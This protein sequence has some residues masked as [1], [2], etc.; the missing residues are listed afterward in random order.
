MPNET[1][2]SGG[3]NP[4]IE[5]TCGHPLCRWLLDGGW[6]EHPENR[7]DPSELW[8]NG[9]TPSVCITGGCGNHE[10]QS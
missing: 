2:V 3:R 5:K 1:F 9:F 6:C 7:V 10:K 8:P 4:N